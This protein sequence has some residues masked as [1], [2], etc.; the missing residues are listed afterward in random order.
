MPGSVLL[1]LLVFVAAGVGFVYCVVK[2]LQALSEI[3]ILHVLGKDGYE[4]L[5]DELESEDSK[6]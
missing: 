1:F 3:H 2:G 4:E 5:L 6:D